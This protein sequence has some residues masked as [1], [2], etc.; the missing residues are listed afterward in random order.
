MI[1][2]REILCNYFASAEGGC[3]ELIEI[4]SASPFTFFGKNYEKAAPL[5]RFPEK[6]NN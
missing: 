5:F 2:G 3:S 6:T 4:G 1:A